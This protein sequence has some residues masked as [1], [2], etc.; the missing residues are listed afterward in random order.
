VALNMA[1]ASAAASKAAI[2]LR[3][4]GHAALREVR[5]KGLI[6]TAVLAD[7]V[8]NTCDRGW[9]TVGRYP[10]LGEKALA[11][12][13]THMPPI[14]GNGGGRNRLHG[15]TFRKTGARRR[16]RSAAGR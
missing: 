12:S 6:A 1:T 3:I 4:N 14:V 8:R 15:D 13:H 5:G 7:T 11:V 16:R 9:L 10:P 2:I